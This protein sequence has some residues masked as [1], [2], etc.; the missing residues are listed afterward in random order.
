MDS[1]PR[2]ARYFVC[3]AECRQAAHKAS[4]RRMHPRLPR[5]ERQCLCGVA[6]TPK[7]NE[8][9]FCWLP[10]SSEHIERG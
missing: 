1:P 4:Y 5:V 9:K 8:A 3:G 7:R 6:F 10:A 2:K